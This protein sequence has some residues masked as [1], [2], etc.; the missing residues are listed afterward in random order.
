MI[1]KLYNND[2]TVDYHFDKTE[3][4]KVLAPFCKKSENNDIDGQV[5]YVSSK[6]R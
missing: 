4:D 6:G 5:L 3:L 1:H 2:G